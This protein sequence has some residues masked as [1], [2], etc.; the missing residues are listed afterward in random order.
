MKLHTITCHMTRVSTP[1][2]NHSQTGQFSIY[3]F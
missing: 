1:C 2:H 3:L